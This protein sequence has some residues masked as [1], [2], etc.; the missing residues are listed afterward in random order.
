MRQMPSFMRRNALRLLML[1]HFALRVYRG[2]LHAF[3][4]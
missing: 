1:Y 4:I 2:A 3:R